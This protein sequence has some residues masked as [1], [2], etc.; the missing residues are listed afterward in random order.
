[1]QEFWEFIIRV[2]MKGTEW[3]L[4]LLLFNCSLLTCLWAW[5]VSTLFNRLLHLM[6]FMLMF[7]RWNLLLSNVLLLLL[8]LYSLSHL[9]FNNFWSFLNINILGIKLRIDFNLVLLD[10]VRT[11]SR[12]SRT[13]LSFLHNR[14]VDRFSWSSMSTLKILFF[15]KIRLFNI[16]MVFHIIILFWH[17]RISTFD[18]IYLTRRQSDIF[19]HFTW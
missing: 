4:L 5:M 14:L 2:S 3:N 17:N 18:F 15:S 19:S 16:N 9:L 6:N 1:M 13:R 8:R 10:L 12:L 7:M 11:L